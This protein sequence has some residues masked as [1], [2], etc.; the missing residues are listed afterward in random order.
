MFRHV[1]FAFFI[2]IRVCFG[3]CLICNLDNDLENDLW[4]SETRYCAKCTW[5]SDILPSCWTLGQ[6]CNM[7]RWRIVL[8]IYNY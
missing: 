6:V 2:H 8:F 7:D 3:F 5:N 4:Q 1:Y